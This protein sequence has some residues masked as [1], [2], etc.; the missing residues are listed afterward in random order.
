MATTTLISVEEYLRTTYRPDCDYVDGEVQERNMGETP[1]A[2]LQSFFLRYFALH[3]DEWQIEALPE[4]RVHVAP[5]RYRIPDVMLAALPNLDE[6]IVRTPPILCVEVLS[7]E[8]RM[9]RVKD[10][11]DDYAKMGVLAAWV[12]DP[13]RRLIHVAGPD[14]VLHE[15]QDRLTVPNRPI[16]I[17]V[18]EIW[19]ELERLEKRA[20]G[21]TQQ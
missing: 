7:S 11:I 3:E 8:D 12:I 4:Q 13:W 18:A 14:G 2:R 10:R 15:E 20:A 6:R 19:A 16:T 9:Y 1:H 21:N 5:R 17:T